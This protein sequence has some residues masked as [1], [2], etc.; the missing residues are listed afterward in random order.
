MRGGIL[1]TLCLALVPLLTGCAGRE[2]LV[3]RPADRPAVQVRTIFVGSTRAVDPDTRQFTAERGQGLTLARYAVSVPRDRRPGSVT[4]PLP[5]EL[6][7]PN[8]HFLIDSARLYD[9]PQDFTGEIAPLLRADRHREAVIFVHGFNNTFA[10]SLYRFAQ[11]A[12]DVDLPGLA[13]HYAWPSAGNALV[14]ARDRDSTLIARDGLE[15]LLRQVRAAGAERIVLV[16]HSM[17]ALLVMETLRQIAIA[18]GSRGLPPGLAVVLA[19]PD[20]DLQVFRAQAARIGQLPQ[21]FVIFASP[22]DAVLRLSALLTAEESRL[23]SLADLQALSDLEVTVVDVS[24]FR[25]AQP[26]FVAATSPLLLRLLHRV[27]DLDAA[28]SDERARMGIFEGTVLSL[29]RATR[30]VL[31]PVAEVAVRV[32]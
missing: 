9:S 5:H 13:I 23:G 17:G 4:R 19:S 22:D 11:I 3:S 7:D 2:D 14:Y 31:S 6:G 28:L 29:R 15:T 32:R 24:A 12:A 16:G 25:D 21:P 30:I 18:E 26:H 20:I 10:E 1:A 8:R 27:T